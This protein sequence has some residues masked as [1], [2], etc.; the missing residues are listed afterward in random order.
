MLRRE[1]GV[2]EVD[3]QL[4]LLLFEIVKVIRK[5]TEGGSQN[6]DLISRDEE[7]TC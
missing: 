5:D 6:P 4:F 3:I 1:G 7:S 2:E